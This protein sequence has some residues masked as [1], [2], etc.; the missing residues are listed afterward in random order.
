MGWEVG[1][2]FKRKRTNVFLWL[3][4]V[5]VQQK[6][7][8][9]CKAIILQLIDKKKFSGQVSGIQRIRGWR[10]RVLRTGAQVTGEW[11]RQE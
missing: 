6:P 11:E 1:E 8:Q 9:Y 2:W 10:S 4:H 7:I 3:I 5:D